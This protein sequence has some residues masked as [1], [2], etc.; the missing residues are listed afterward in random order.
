MAGG[1]TGAA[2]AAAAENEDGRPKNAKCV[3][4]RHKLRMK[5]FARVGGKAEGG[6]YIP[7]EGAAGFDKSSTFVV[8]RDCEWLLLET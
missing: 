6:I 1:G 8:G 2:A 5:Y 4:T 3:E 7:Q